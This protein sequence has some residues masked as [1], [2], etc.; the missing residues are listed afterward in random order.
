M[1][2]ETLH[3][4]DPDP[5]SAKELLEA[6]SEEYGAGAPQGRIPP[7]VVAN[8][9]RVPQVRKFFSDTP[10]ESIAYLSH[11]VT[12][13]TRRAVELLSP[14]DLRPPG[15]REYVGPMVEFFKEHE[16]DPSYAPKRD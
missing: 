7:S 6:L 5:L 12:F 11:P 3:L 9:L 15:F 1:V 16:D 4:V 2:G 10:S 13:D 14:H 8:A